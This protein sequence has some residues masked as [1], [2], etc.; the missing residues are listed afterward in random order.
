MIR[1]SL[2]AFFVSALVVLVIIKLSHSW[3]YDPV[4]AGPQKFHAKPTPRIGGVAILLGFL[5]GLVYLYFANLK[6]IRLFYLLLSTF[7]AFF[8]GL[9]EDIT[10]KIPAKTRFLFISM[11][12]LFAVLSLD[13]LVNRVGVPVFDDVIKVYVVSLLFTVFALVGLA[14]AINII[15][16]FNGLASGVSIFI[17]LA[18]AYVAFENSDGFV[19]AVSLIL[20]GA[21]AGF[22]IFNYPYGLI[23]LGDGGAYLIGFLIGVLSVMLVKNHPQVSP[24]FALSVSVYPVYETLFSIYRRKFLKGSSATAPDALHLHTLFYK[25][26]VKKLLGTNNP[27]YRNP[28]VSPLMWL[29]NSLGVIPAILFWNNT[30]LLMLSV[31]IFIAVYTY[32]YFSIIRAKLPKS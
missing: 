11:S 14:N 28:A 8:I 23:F 25:T 32:I 9:F 24:W 16:G 10:K 3:F 6:D 17:L 2:I 19:L 13:V 18:I 31:F 4:K 27:L 12:G 21:I 22:F 26:V 7:P 20:A 29:L 15:D 1:A 5:C 30:Y